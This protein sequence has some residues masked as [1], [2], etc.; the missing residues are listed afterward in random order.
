M[1]ELFDIGESLSPRLKWMRE[2]EV[3]TFSLDEGYYEE[4]NL[5][6]WECTSNKGN[7]RKGKGETEDEA[8]ID[9][10]RKNN[11]RLWNEE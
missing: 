11:L 9:F 6:P 3:R 1:T 2:H 10:A 5:D 4:F 8:I 7:F